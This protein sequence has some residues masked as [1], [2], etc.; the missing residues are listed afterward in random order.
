MPKV[1]EEEERGPPSQHVEGEDV[2][3]DLSRCFSMSRIAPDPVP[4]PSECTFE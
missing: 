1:E 2:A 4:A 3:A